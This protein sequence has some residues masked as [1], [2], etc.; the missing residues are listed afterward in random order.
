[1]SE[2]FLDHAIV[3]RPVFV[4]WYFVTPVVVISSPELIKYGLNFESPKSTLNLQQH[5]IFIWKIQIH[6]IWSI[7]LYSIKPRKMEATLKGT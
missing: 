1:M 5:S 7:Y 2:I 6:W 3:Y 4:W